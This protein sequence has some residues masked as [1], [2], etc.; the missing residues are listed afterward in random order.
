MQTTITAARLGT[1]APSLWAPAREHAHSAVA[2][3]DAQTYAAAYVESVARLCGGV[4]ADQ[5]A[6]GEEWAPADWLAGDLARVQEAAALVGAEISDEDW[7]RL[8]SVYAEGD[9]RA[10]AD[11]GAC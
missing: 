5:C 1:L 11:H 8:W 6:D 4:A 10:A 7:P 9:V 3:C 2:P